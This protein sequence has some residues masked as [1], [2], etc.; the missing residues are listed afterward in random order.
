MVLKLTMKK[1][2]QAMLFFRKDIINN[3]II[4]LKEK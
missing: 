3:K 4:S 1:R 2:G